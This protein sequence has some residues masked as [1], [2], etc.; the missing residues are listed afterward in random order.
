[1]SVM[2]SH[3]LVVS[4]T[5]VGGEFRSYFIFLLLLQVTHVS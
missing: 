4:Y 1:M 5:A 3:S 2:L